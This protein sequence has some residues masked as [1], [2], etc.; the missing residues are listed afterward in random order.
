M[1][2]SFDITHLGQWAELYPIFSGMEIQLME[3]E[4]TLDIF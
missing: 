4:E 2:M 1:C 3:V